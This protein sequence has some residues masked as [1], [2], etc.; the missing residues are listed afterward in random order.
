MLVCKK[1]RTV[2]GK[3]FPFSLFPISAFTYQLVQEEF[4]RVNVGFQSIPG[5]LHNNGIISDRFFVLCA[6]IVYKIFDP[7]EQET[8][9][10]VVKGL[11][12]FKLAEIFIIKKEFF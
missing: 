8:V 11:A 3:S 6:V 1:S 12:V 9:K 4:F 7:A 2:V 10:L 5:I